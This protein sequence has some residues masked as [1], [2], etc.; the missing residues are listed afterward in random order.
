MTFIPKHLTDFPTINSDFPFDLSVHTLDSGYPAHRHDF[1]EFSLVIEGSGE[2]RINEN[3][4]KMERGTF[5]FVK[6]Y[7]IHEI[8]TTKGTPLKLFN[9]NFGME[10]FAHTH[11]Y[12]GINHLL[13][14]EDDKLSSYVQFE[15]S[16]LHHVRRLLE[17]ILEEYEHTA[18]WRNEIILSKLVEIIIRFDRSRREIN[19]TLDHQLSW[20]PEKALIW[21]VIQFIHKHYREELSLTILSKQFMIST[22]SLSDL[23]RK[24][25]GQNFLDFLHDVRIRH[26][27]SLLVS[28]ELNVSEI[29]HETGFGSYKSFS[30]VF[31]S[32]KNVS[33]GEYRKSAKKAKMKRQ[34]TVQ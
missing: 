27:C 13:F 18:I 32:K 9:C 4:H 31:R 29:S 8:R 34:Q 33:A 1:F 22:S 19:T 20:Q 7:Q 10:L 11:S 14:A 3:V 15:T 5:T 26:A 23:F 24:E 12:F 21:D 17:E 6:P 16:Q 30:R 28:S 2:E 25:I